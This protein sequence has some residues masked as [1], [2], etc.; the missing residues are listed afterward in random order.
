MRV[1]P[2]LRSSLLLVLKII[3]GEMFIYFT[4]NIRRQTSKRSVKSYSGGGLVCVGSGVTTG[5]VWK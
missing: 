3:P 5:F 4:P 1:S 2:F